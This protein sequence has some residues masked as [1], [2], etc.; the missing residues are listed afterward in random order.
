MTLP[1]MSAG[2]DAGMPGLAPQRPVR[3]R[4][5]S[6]PRTLVAMATASS[7]TDHSL[8]G[9]RR[10][11]AGLVLVLLAAACAGPADLS[12][13][14]PSVPVAS[15]REPGWAQLPDPP[16]K[17]RHGAIAVSTGSSV[18]VF[19]GRDAPPCPPT[20]GCAGAVPA[21]LRDGARF[22]VASQ[23]WTPIASLPVGVAN[24][25]TATLQGA[26]FVWATPT[27]QTQPATFL[28]YDL[29]ADRWEVLPIPDVRPTGTAITSGNDEVL[30]VHESQEDAAAP[31]LRFDPRDE[32]WRALPP[33]PLAPSFERDMTQVGELLVLTAKELPT[34]TDAPPAAFRAAT[35]T[36]D[37]WQTLPDGDVIGSDSTWLPVG[38]LLVNPT[39]GH[40]EVPARGD[41]A[42]GGT[43]K[44]RT[45][46]WSRLPDAPRGE[47]RGGLV[48]QAVG[49]HEL[50]VSHRGWALIIDDRRWEAPGVPPAGPDEGAAV[51]VAAGSLYVVG[52]VRH[53]PGRASELL[54]HAWRWTPSRGE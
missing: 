9:G 27:D 51:A 6:S 12:E 49:D 47:V 52:G 14:A 4:P 54:P 20:A 41:V 37:G 11:A 44:P 30:L 23:T 43:L 5:V 50:L 40:D 7:R 2:P 8:R 38:D 26:I 18:L 22:D 28:R 31:D 15:S 32:E 53:V 21:S 39:P 33:D 42:H 10:G 13:T 45:G 3:F 17:P 35:W 24:A 1:A 25:S 19:G 48:S 46:E 16:L 29:A 34:G 36:D